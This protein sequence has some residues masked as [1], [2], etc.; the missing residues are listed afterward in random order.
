MKQLQNLLNLI[1]KFVLI[2]KLL[3]FTRK[4]TIEI[5]LNLGFDGF[6]DPAFFATL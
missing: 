5:F 2:F 6:F 3:A 1:N 4:R